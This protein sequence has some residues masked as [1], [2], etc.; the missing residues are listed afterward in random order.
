MAAM[1]STAAVS[2][3]V[4]PAASGK[5]MSARSSAFSAAMPAMMPAKRVTA[6]VRARGAVRVVA[7]LEEPLVKIGT[8]GR[9][10]APP[11]TARRS[12]EPVVHP[13]DAPAPAPSRAGAPPTRVAKPP[14]RRSPI[15]SRGNIYLLFYPPPLTRSIPTPAPPPPLF[16]APSRWRR[17]T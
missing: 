15:A 1:M 9:C 3:R 10:A 5:K 6:T 17:R 11:S 2:A 7:E 12:R 4:A 8:R 16:A 13:P 14:G